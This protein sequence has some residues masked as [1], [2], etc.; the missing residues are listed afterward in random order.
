MLLIYNLVVKLP[1][2]F[3]DNPDPK[4]IPTAFKWIKN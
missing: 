4:N 2:Y 1:I 3:I